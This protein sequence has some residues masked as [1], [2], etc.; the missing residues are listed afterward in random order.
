MR[1]RDRTP[2]LVSLRFINK[3][4][5]VL[6]FARGLTPAPF[7]QCIEERRAKIPVPRSG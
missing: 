4:A 6:D 2:Q 1:T 5:M 7:V 3:V